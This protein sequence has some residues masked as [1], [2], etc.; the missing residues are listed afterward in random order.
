MELKHE[1]MKLERKEES[2][3]AEYKMAIDI[4]NASKDKWYRKYY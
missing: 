2:M 3:M 1:F 4:Q